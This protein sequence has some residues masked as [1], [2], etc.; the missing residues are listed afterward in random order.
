MELYKE[1][2][3]NGHESAKYNLAIYYYSIGDIES[4][5]KL[6]NELANKNHRRAQYNLAFLYLEKYQDI[7]K[8]KFWFSESYKNGYADAGLALKQ[9]F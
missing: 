4:T 3:A 6:Y 7:E 9:F 5:L 1:V 2:S 8:A